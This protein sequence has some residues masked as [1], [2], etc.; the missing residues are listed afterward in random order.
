MIFS[1]VIRILESQ[2]SEKFNEI[3]GE[4]SHLKITTVI[5]HGFVL[6]FILNTTVDGSGGNRCGHAFDK[7]VIN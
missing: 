7:L 3:Q 4:M 6:C 5:L 2:L 1:S